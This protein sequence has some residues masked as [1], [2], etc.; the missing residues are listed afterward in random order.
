MFTIPSLRAR[1]CT[2]AEKDALNILFL[3]VPLLNVSL[4]FLSKSFP[5]IFSADCVL[6]A[7]VFASK[8]LIPGLGA[9]AA[10]E[11]NQQ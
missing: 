5:L 10:D 7:A 9:A 6:M 11:G 4:P 1:E 8:G 2:P 3:A